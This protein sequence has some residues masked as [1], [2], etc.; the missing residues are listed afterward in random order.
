MKGAAPWAALVALLALSAAACVSPLVRK[1]RSIVSL[2]SGASIDQAGTVETPARIDTAAAD[3]S[4]TIPKDSVFSFDP[5][6]QKL[7]LTVARDTAAAAHSSDEHAT[8]AKPSAPLSPVELAR[9]ST[10]AKFYWIALALGLLAGLFLWRAHIKAGVICGAGAVAVPILAK[11]FSSD[12]AQYVALAVLCVSSALFWAWH[13]MTARLNQNL[14]PALAVAVT[15][16]VSG[17]RPSD[18][19]PLGGLSP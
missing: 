18:A 9:A 7:S 2:P 12:A 3:F 4:F 16:A 8:A 15:A 1:A 5:R 13:M 6:A 14:A 17:A 11:F 19:A 10:L